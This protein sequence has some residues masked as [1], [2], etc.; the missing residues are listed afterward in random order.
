MRDAIASLTTR[1]RAFV[2]SGLTAIGCALLLGLDDLGR[3]G[4]LLLALPLVSALAVTRGRHQLTLSRSLSTAQVPVSQPAH[5]RLAVGNEGRAPTGLLLLEEQ[6]PP[7]LGPR[8]RFIVDRM[9]PRWRRTVTYP[10]VSELRGRFQV[11]PLQVRVSDPFGLVEVDHTFRSTSALVVTPPVLPL[12]AV[13][14]TGTWTGSGD[15]RPRDFAGGSAEDVTV[16]E[17]RRGDDL[18]R[19]HWRSSAHAGELMVR[20]EEQ[21]WQSRATVFIDNRRHVHQGSGTTSTLEYAV[22]AAASVAMHLARRGFRV[23]LLT[24]EGGEAGA[25]PDHGW[26]EHGATA[27]E[28]GPLLESLAVLRA[29]PQT[30]LDARWLAD[31]PRTGLLVGV[32]GAVSAADQGVLSRIRHAA[33]GAMAIAPDE[34]ATALLIATGW[35]AVTAAPGQPLAAVWRELGMAVPTAGSAR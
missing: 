1:G 12:P 18:R 4:G 31:A 5:A 7:A 14:L 34:G 19:V 2:S 9:G 20:R 13:P 28:A 24:A 23:R 10:V 3:V 26:H 30:Q 16:R 33:S 17:Y 21:P 15:N 29:T 32:M 27:S 25:G 22:T 8:P 11:G 35:R 6:V